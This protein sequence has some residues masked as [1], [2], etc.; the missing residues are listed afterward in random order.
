MNRLTGLATAFVAQLTRNPHGQARL[1][2]E[3][4]VNFRLRGDDGR[5]RVVEIGA[6][7]MALR[8]VADTLFRAADEAEHAMQ[9]LIVNPLVKTADEAREF[10]VEID[11]VLD[12]AAAAKASGDED[13][14]ARLELQFENSAAYLRASG[15]D[16]RN[17]TKRA[18]EGDRFPAEITP[19]IGPEIIEKLALESVEMNSAPIEERA[20]KV[21]QITDSLAEL[22]RKGFHCRD[23]VLGRVREIEES[24][25]TPQ[26]N[27]PTFEHWIARAHKCAQ[28]RGG[29]IEPDH[30]PK[31]A[32][33]FDAGMQPAEAVADYLADPEKWEPCGCGEHAAAPSA[34]PVADEQEQPEQ[35]QQEGPDDSDEYEFITATRSADGDLSWSYRAKG[36]DRPGS[37]A[38]DEDVSEWSD[39]DI[40]EL[41]MTTL[42]VPEHQRDLIKIEND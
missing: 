10:V 25:E 8:E 7:P 20:W 27:G 6:S 9:P 38:H 16:Y 13:E 22:S 37:Q 32:K 35:Q 36:S 23:A 3:I 28:M 31:F 34:P 29:I 42:G 41:T 15:W 14:A 17:F 12:A 30:A 18:I 21:K 40:I 11:A 5:E 2:P 26:A 4:R 1:E 24:G 33:A 19:E 39:E